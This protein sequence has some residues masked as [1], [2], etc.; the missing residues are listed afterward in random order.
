MAESKKGQH[1]DITFSRDALVGDDLR[2]AD[3]EREKRNSPMPEE[4]RDNPE[5]LDGWPIPEDRKP[6][7]M[8]ADQKDS[9]DYKLKTYKD[10]EDKDRDHELVNGPG[11]VARREFNRVLRE[12]GPKADM[13]E[14]QAPPTP[15]AVAA[16]EGE[17]ADIQPVP[18]STLSNMAAAMAAAGEIAARDASG[19]KT[20]AK[21]DNN[22]K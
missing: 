11:S 5:K 17:G 21:T 12:A 4:Y 13:N 16:S 15:A 8:R 14:I 10:I 6:A 2:V 20:A 9:L 22:K 19:G 3:E 1:D 18:T 7:V